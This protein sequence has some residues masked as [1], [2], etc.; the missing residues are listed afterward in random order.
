MKKIIFYFSLIVVVLALVIIIINNEEKS[1]SK[2]LSVLQ[3]HSHLAE[4]KQEIE[5]ILYTNDL[6]HP[7]VDVASY[8][9]VYLINKDE[10]KKLQLYLNK[11]VKAHQEQYLNETYNQFILYLELPYLDQDYKIDEAYLQIELINGDQYLIEIGG[12]SLMRSSTAVKH[13]DWNGLNGVKQ[14][15]MHLSR[16]YQI[17]IDY[18]SLNETIEQIAIGVDYS[19]SFVVKQQRIVI[20]IAYENILLFNVPIRITYANGEHQTISNFR[21]IIDYQILKESGMLIRT[22]VLN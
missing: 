2:L 5:I 20:E 21:Y 14:E 11:I 10:S 7:I 4:E 17:F 15:G 12:F 9:S 6:G 13:L 18:V 19:V 1:P 16:L 22:Y 8:A 3:Y